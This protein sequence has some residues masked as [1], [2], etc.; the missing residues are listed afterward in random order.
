MNYDGPWSWDSTKQ[1]KRA[2]RA[3]DR[4]YIERVTKAKQKASNKAARL[5]RQAARARIREKN[6]A[7]LF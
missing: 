3:D 4:A 1:P 6:A 2:Q 7:P 5:R